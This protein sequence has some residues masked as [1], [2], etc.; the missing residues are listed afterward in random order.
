M[1]A[2][3]DQRGQVNAYFR[4]SVLEDGKDEFVIELRLGNQLRF[5]EG[6]PS[7]EESEQM[8]QPVT[9]DVTLRRLQ[10]FEVSRDA[11][12]PYHWMIESEGSIRA[13]GQIAPNGK[14]LLTAKNVEIGLAPIR[15]TITRQAK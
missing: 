8:R 15:L 7:A 5:A 14:G 9:A 1:S 11:S 2:E 3:M 6:L 4:W 12:Q 10:N 13:T